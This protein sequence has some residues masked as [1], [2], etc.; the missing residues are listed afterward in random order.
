MSTTY[1]VGKQAAA[2]ASADGTIYY[3]LFERTYESNVFP[4]SPHWC[5]LYFG[6]AAACMQRIVRWATACEGGCLKEEG[7]WV[8]PS[9][10]IKH[11]REAMASPLGFVRTAV[12]GRF[13][14]GLYELSPDE[15]DALALILA[16][17]RHPGIQ[18]DRISLDLQEHAPIFQAIVDSG[19][20]L[21][22]RFLDRS[23]IEG[24]ASWAAYRPAETTWTLPPVAIWR[25]QPQPSRES[26]YWIGRPDGSFEG[27]GWAYST[28]AKLIDR[29]AVQA[30]QEMPGSAEA[31]IR[32]IRACVKEVSNVPASQV[33]RVDSHRI[34]ESWQQRACQT[35]AAKL[36]LTGSV[37]EMTV[38]AM[39]KA[40]GL[41]ELTSLP[42]AA[43]M[44]PGLAVP[45]HQ[46]LS[47]VA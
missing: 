35:L 3:A 44:F 23:A 46:Q 28:I 4:H 32:Q 11:W 8:S 20:G 39:L 19:K 29:Y 26:E 17:Y 36:G 41:H 9:V 27:T 16:R 24:D 42:T 31:V 33:V 15:R 37:L 43:V 1:S 10:Y 13:G 14:T 18:D 12:T 6:T 40:E 38:A 5:A 47:L 45:L 25:I 22:W 2:I 7:G 21:P 34:T 30:E